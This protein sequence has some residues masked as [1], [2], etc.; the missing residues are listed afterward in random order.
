MNSSILISYGNFI[1]RWRDTIFTITILVAFGLLI[2]GLPGAGDETI[3]RILSAAGLAIAALG[4]LVRIVTIGLAY[5]KRGG[6]GKKISA[7]TVVRRGLFAHTRNPMYVGNLLIVTGAIVFID[8]LYYFPVLLFFYLNY[9]AIIAAE[10]HF[11][12]GKFGA[13]YEDYMQSVNRLIPGNL[14][15]LRESMSEMS[16]TWKRVIKKEHGSIIVLF[17]SMAVYEALKY[18]FRYGLAWGDERIVLCW[19]ILA[20]L[21]VF[22]LVSEILTRTGRLEWDPNRP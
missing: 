9:A 10:E 18:H 12:K 8:I 5:I 15:R 14:G 7:E 2:Y 4:Q 11:L 13:D 17:G 1:F 22:Y 21:A 3:G 16:F 20:V 19:I 6:V